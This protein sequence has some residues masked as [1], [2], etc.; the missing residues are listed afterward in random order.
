MNDTT[1]QRKQ[2]DAPELGASVWL[3]EGSV[4]DV[5]PLMRLGESGDTTELLIAAL[6]A[7]LEV[8]GKRMTD[9]ELRRLPARVIKRLLLLGL[10]ALRINGIVP[11]E[12][13]DAEK[14]G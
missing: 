13:E 6:G 9:A 8:D 4:M 3:V 10:D 14:K 1:R 11:A 5:L 7:S 12:N 2:V